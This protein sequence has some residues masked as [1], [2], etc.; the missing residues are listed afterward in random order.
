MAEGARCFRRRGNYE[1]RRPVRQHERYSPLRGE[2][3]HAVARAAANILV[4]FLP[5]FEIHGTLWL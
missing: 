4:L 1:E 2:G 5:V 3:E